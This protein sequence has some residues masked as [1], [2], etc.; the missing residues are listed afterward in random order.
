MDKVACYQAVTHYRYTT[1]SQGV[2]KRIYTCKEHSDK[3]KGDTKIAN[4]PINLKCGV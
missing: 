3:S 4:A 2:K 1:T